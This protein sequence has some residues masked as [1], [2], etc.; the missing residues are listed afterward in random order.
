VAQRDGSERSLNAKADVRLAVAQD[1]V[2]IANVAQRTW[3]DTYAGIILPE[4]QERFLGR[5][6][7]PAVLEEAIGRS[8]SWLYVAVVEAEVIGFA[9]FMMRDD[10]RGEL[11]RIYVLPEWQRRGVGSRLLREGLAALSAHGAQEVFVHVERDNAKG[12]GFYE[13]SGFHQVR[14]FSAELPEQNLELLEY[15]LS[16]GARSGSPV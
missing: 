1:A 14:G 10:G 4:T 13:R 2:G 12:T 11:T 6:Y 15:A 3:K 9:Q 7:T 16:L 5:W 8:E